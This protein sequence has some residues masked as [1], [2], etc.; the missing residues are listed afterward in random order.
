[1]TP[2]QN[3]KTGHNWLHSHPPYPYFYLLNHTLKENWDCAFNPETKKVKMHETKEKNGQF[4]LCML[5]HIN[6]SDRDYFW[7]HCFHHLYRHM[8]LMQCDQYIMF[9]QYRT[10]S[11]WQK[12]KFI[13]QRRWWK[14]LTWCTPR[15]D[16]YPKWNMVCTQ[17]EIHA[18]TQLYFSLGTK[19]ISVWGQ[20]LTADSHSDLDSAM[21]LL[22]S[23]TFF[24]LLNCKNMHLFFDLQSFLH[25][26]DISTL[27]YTLWN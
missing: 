19:G 2:N 15:V 5:V 14:F 4:V 21:L 22:S 8:Q 16:E 6:N 12:Q 23:A 24:S 3:V 26:L 17:T 25:D 9:Q 1:M 18:G 27:V 20:F 10:Y 13:G 11:L 7:T